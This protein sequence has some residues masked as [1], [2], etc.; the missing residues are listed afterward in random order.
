MKAILIATIAVIFSQNVYAQS[1]VWDNIKIR[2]D[3]E[4]G[5]NDDDKAANLSFTFPKDK[6]NYFVVNAG[7][8][9]Q[10]DNISGDHTM[11]KNSITG[12]FAYNRNN[13]IDKEQNNFKIGIS[14]GMT[15]FTDNE[16]QTALFGS[17]TLEYLND[18]SEDSQSM[19]ITS[20]WYPFSK[21]KEFVKLGG[22]VAEEHLFAY[23]FLP[24]AGLEYQNKFEAALPESNGYHVRGYFGLGANLLLKKP[25]A[26]HK[27]EPVPKSFWS[28]GMELSV[29]YEARKNL[30][31]NVDNTD[32][33]I[34]MFTSE[35][36]IYPTQDNKFS[37][38][39]SYTNGANPI[40]G[41]EKQTFWLLAIKFKK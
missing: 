12:F 37:I 10:Y 23:H 11:F 40:N 18:H 26:N 32:S 34:P 8:G 33:Y 27:K 36:N 22:Y 19:A 5:T 31:S 24:T 7:V 6:S 29:K 41:L 20:Y 38:G 30:L 2:K 3:F 9:Y 14:N 25:P 21:K 13:Q 28:K 39:L 17:N 15:I 16:Q 35:L 1:T 4:T